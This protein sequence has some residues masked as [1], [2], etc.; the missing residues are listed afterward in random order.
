[1]VPDAESVIVAYLRDE[2]FRVSTATPD[3]RED[4]WVRVT[5]L[6]DS[7]TDGG[8]TDHHIEAFLQIDCYAGTAENSSV[9]ASDL[10]IDVREALRTMKDAVLDG[11]VVT[12]AQSSRTHVPDT[13]IGE[14]ALERYILQS[15][16]YMHARY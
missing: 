14:A 13:A 5:L 1:M 4:P 12:G 2:A 15:T 10:S 9:V 16:V 6:D 8:I 11:A 3:D 7:S